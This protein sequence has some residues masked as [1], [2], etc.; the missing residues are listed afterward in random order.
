MNGMRLAV[1]ARLSQVLTAFIIECDNEF[2]H[3]MPHRT[4]RHGSAGDL[5]RPPWLVS[6]AM[7]ANC[8]RLVPAD[9]IAAG[10]L[11][12][13]AR[14]DGHSMDLVLTR[15]SKWWGYLTVAPGA[16]AGRR[17]APTR[18]GRQAQETWAPL[19]GE[20]EDRWR[21]RFGRDAIEELRAALVP[22]VAQLGMRLPDFLPAGK[23]QPEE[24]REDGAGL[25]L[26]A[27]LSKVLLALALDFERESR[28]TLGIYTGRGAARLAISANVLRVL[29]DDGSRVRDLPAATGVAQM[30]IGNW[31]GSLE[32][33]RYLTVG[34]D[35]AGGR[36][37][38]AQLTARGREARDSYLGW[39]AADGGQRDAAA[40]R[41]ALA[42]FGD[43]LLR[44]GTEPY[45]D[46]WRAKV[47][48]P[49]T[50]P[51]YP[52]ISPRGGFPDGS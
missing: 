13:R 16:A 17:V 15:M 3:R 18:A 36:F 8:L 27:L 41:A 28:L 37:K 42:P 21:D 48:R 7:W 4:T 44:S 26:P 11:A 35:P 24:G 31:L 40:L 12:R 14:L 6:M 30:T 38:V 2:E 20:I 43:D 52:V 39:A 45:P 23:A 22:A 10:E 1:P 29:A 50:L 25:A 47:A 34:P 33:H 51:H 19:P 5:R 46:G 49:A 9:G 32:E